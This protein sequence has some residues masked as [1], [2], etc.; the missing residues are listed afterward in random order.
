MTQSHVIQVVTPPV[1][2]VPGGDFSVY[3]GFYRV[4]SCPLACPSPCRVASLFFGG[5]GSKASGFMEYSTF[6]LI[7]TGGVRFFRRQAARG[8]EQ[9]SQLVGVY[10][11]DQDGPFGAAGI[12][13]QSRAPSITDQ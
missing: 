5:Q 2:T 11:L 8:R 9:G 1:S 12:L 7:R 3:G 4:K 10:G 13:Q 6:R